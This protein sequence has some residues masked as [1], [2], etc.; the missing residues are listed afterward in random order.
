MALES[1]GFGS[2]KRLILIQGKVEEV[3]M[4]SQLSML[5]YGKKCR[6]GCW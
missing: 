2:V 1:L 5:K 4:L 6:Y 3:V